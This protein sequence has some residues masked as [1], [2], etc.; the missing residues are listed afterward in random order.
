[1]NKKK[2]KWQKIVR[3]RLVPLPSS[4]HCEGWTI[5]IKKYAGVGLNTNLAGGT[6]PQQ[7]AVDSEKLIALG[8]RIHEKIKRDPKFVE[9]HIKD[10]YQACEAF[11]EA[12]KNAASGEL[13]SLD[14]SQLLERFQ[15]VLE[16]WKHFAIFLYIPHAV[17]SVL[18]AELEK[19]FGEQNTGEVKYSDLLVAPK[20]PEST[21][22]QH[23]LTYLA[24]E[25]EDGEIK[26]YSK[27]L[28]RHHRKYCWLSVYENDEQ[29]FTL[30]DFQKRLKGLLNSDLRKRIGEIE[31]GKKQIKKVDRQI[32]THLKGELLSLLTILREYIFLRS[33][34]TEMMRKAMF[35]SQPLLKEIA[36]RANLTLSELCHLTEGEVVGF[37]KNRTLVPKEEIQ[38]RMKAWAILEVEGSYSFYSGEEAIKVVEEAFGRKGDPSTLNEVTGTVASLGRAQGKVR[39]ILDKRRAHELQKGEVLVA[40]MTQ[41]EYMVAIERCIAIVTDE[42]GVLCHAA[43]VSR[44]M[45]IPCV[46]GTEVATKVFK[47]GDLV[48]VDAGKGIVGKLEKEYLG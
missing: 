31:E 11:V 21:I 30:Q 26:D 18:G 22:E 6:L 24:K 5:N 29:P 34:R 45:N 32:K 23:E 33:Y 2:I 39:I 40:V 10:C 15:K 48:E 12:G 13:T 20:Y 17:E 3:R 7:L 43:I 42:G 8:K 27:L 19:L 4:V 46:I 25:I 14:L 35:N 1:M 44:E 41:P 16:P 28:R 38:E 36:E 37:L 47:T 9:Q